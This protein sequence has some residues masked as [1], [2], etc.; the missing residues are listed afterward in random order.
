MFAGRAPDVCRLLQLSLRAQLRHGKQHLSTVLMHLM[1]LAFLIDQI[2]QRCCRL[3]QTAL[4]AAKSKTRLWQP[5]RSVPDPQLGGALS[6]HHRSATDAFAARHLLAERRERLCSKP[7]L[8][9]HR[10]P[11][12]SAAPPGGERRAMPECSPLACTPAS[13][14][15]GCTRR[16]LLADEQGNCVSAQAASD[17][18]GQ[19]HRRAPDCAMPIGG[20][21]GQGWQEA[22][23]TLRL[24]SRN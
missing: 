5:L 18:Q 15:S 24:P 2:Q 7:F 14:D 1:M 3:F 11:T 21:A 22:Q 13:I 10:K 12:V 4:T 8:R 9:G 19:A 6:V 20:E 17:L 16:E 23:T